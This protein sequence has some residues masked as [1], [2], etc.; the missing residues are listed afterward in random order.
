MEALSQRENH[1]VQVICQK[2]WLDWQA[3]S[4]GNNSLSAFRVRFAV[5]KSFSTEVIWFEAPDSVYMGDEEA[6]KR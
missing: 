1:P 6:G 3:L 2:I 5:S 4:I